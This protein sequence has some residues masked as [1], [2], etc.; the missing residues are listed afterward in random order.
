[1]NA[2]APTNQGERAMSKYEDGRLK[3]DLFAI[4]GPGLYILATTLFVGMTWH[5]GGDARGAFDAAMSFLGQM[6]GEWVL[7]LGLLFF[8][9]L[10]GS[11]AR[12]ISVNRA[13]HLCKA[14]FRRMARKPYDQSL[15]E[16]AFPYRTIMEK[17]LKA[18][19]K[20]RRGYKFAI[21]EPGTAHTEFNLWKAELAEKA[22]NTFGFVRELEARV[23][24][25]AGMTWA[26]AWGVLTALVG[27]LGCW[28]LGAAPSQ[29]LVPLLLQLALSKVFFVGYCS[30]VR[31][32]RG[33]EVEQVFLAI[34]LLRNDNG[35]EGQSVPLPAP[36]SA[37]IS[38]A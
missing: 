28:Q 35:R 29:W 27:M 38:A 17:T 13:D 4:I 19:E 12:A 7:A 21:P 36:L 30:Q 2:N 33:Q 8:A 9:Y 11:F 32:V 34:I 10:L 6:T 15:F 37:S 25:F 3:P 18:V 31:R 5:Q 24:L 22:S 23:R 16:S 20:N 14:L 1:M 26:G